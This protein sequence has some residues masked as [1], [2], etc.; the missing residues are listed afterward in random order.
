[1]V[2]GAE[3]S[4]ARVTLIRTF[5]SRSRTLQLCQGASLDLG[6]TDLGIA[7]PLSTSGRFIVDAHGKRVRLAGVNWY[8]AHEDLGVAPGLDRTDRRALARAIAMQGFNSVRLPFSLWMTEQ[9]SPVPDQYLAANPDLAGATPMQVYDTCVQALTGEDLIVIPNCHILDAGWC[10]SEDDGNGLWYNR[11]WPA[12]KFFAAWQDIAARYQANPLVAAM[13]IMNEP[14]RTTAGWRVLTPT[15]GTRPKTDIAAMYATAGNLI[16]QISPHVLII[17]EGLNYAADLS[18]VARHPVRL[19]RPGQVVYSLHD[20]AWFHPAGQPR[21]AYF[22]QMRR[23]GG[24]ILSEQIAP[25]W[26]GEFG[27]DTR[28]LASFGLA[29]SQAGHAGSA[30]WWN[31]FQAW[32]TGNDVDWCWWALNPTQPKG[33]IPVAGRHRSSWGDPEPWG[34]LAPDWR[35]VANPGVL[36]LL[37]AMIPPRTGPG[38][39]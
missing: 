4:A 28:S 26:V 11:R 29:P 9:V 6:M 23:S 5:L 32:L 16:H 37:K 39:T 19:E 13:D 27:N 34:L 38:I 10:C 21:Q 31:N 36:D 7:T 1:M 15:W 22:D 18:G 12:T 35:G 17:C 3:A 25:V 24:Y 8:G 30:V 2:A 33:T 20:Y 14:R